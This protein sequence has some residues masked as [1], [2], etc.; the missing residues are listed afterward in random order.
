MPLS[1][2]ADFAGYR[3]IRTLGSG[4]MGEVYL[5]QHPRLPRRDALKLLPKEWSGDPQYRSRFSREADLASTL[6]HP[7]IV[8]V[9]DRGEHDSVLWIA[10]DFVDGADLGRQLS[11]KYP[12]GM[13]A[14]QVIPIVAAVA[15][16]LDYA[17]KKGLLHR[18]VKPAN[19]M[20]TED[21]DGDQRVVLADF[22]I[23]RNI[24][25]VS[26]LTT[27][28][29]TVGTVAYAAPEQLMGEEIDGRADQ[30]ALAATAF[31]LLTGVPLFPN[32]NP[33][34]V[35][36]KH[37]NSP[38][39]A[40]VDTHAELAALDPAFTKALA[41]SPGDRYDRCVDFVRALEG[42]TTTESTTKRA[43]AR[44]QAARAQR[45]VVSDLATVAA[46]QNRPWLV[47]AV[48]AGSVILLSGTL[49]VWRPW[50]SDNLAESGQSA[51]TDLS[52]PLPSSSIDAPLN[53]FSPTAPEPAPPVPM[54]PLPP[55]TT[56]PPAENGYALTACFTSSDP[57]M[58]RPTS[59]E[60]LFCASGGLS[61]Q[62]MTWTAW[63][64]DGADGTGVAVFN[65][66]KPSC[67][68]G[69][70]VSNKVDIRAW[71]PQPVSASSGCPSSVLYY[72]DIVL[73]FPMSVPPEDAGMQPNTR[74][75]G[76][77]AMHFATEPNPPL[78]T[79]SMAEAS[80]Y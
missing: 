39:P 59:A 21:E 62:D 12:V 16:A 70:Q 22:G 46:P 40:L 69:Y 6:W 66:C 5:A 25:D 55:T 37:L 65:V 23:A 33:A 44:T 4:G 36:S 26:G 78:P 29:M 56:A 61:L 19:I 67:A 54:V 7:N 15:N 18:D 43:A 53:P 58:D 45:P 52:S 73:A 57:P 49:L 34:V 38:P 72:N 9:H 14:D 42:R 30:Y 79:E 13:P 27:T 3:I 51:S 35:I 76:L 32:S 47:P 24:D 71:N 64:R 77:P 41:K 20:L 11:D 50:S 48:V 60:L 2:G 63:G 31:H 10:M 80:C 74:F 68:D 75:K 17:H 28:N 1:N 8:G